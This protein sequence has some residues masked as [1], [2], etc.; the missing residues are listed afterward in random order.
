MRNSRD[1]PKFLGTGNRLNK[2]VLGTDPRYRR[3]FL[4]LGMAAFLTSIFSA[5]SSQLMNKYLEDVHGFSSS[6][7]A[8]FRT[9][10][11]GIPGLVGL[12]LGGRLAEKRGRRPVAAIG[13]AIATATQM[14]FFLD[15][16][17]HHLGD[18]GGLDPRGRCRR[19]RAR[20][21]RR[22]AVRHRS[23]VD[24]ERACSRSSVWSVRLSGLIAAGVLADPLGDLG[25]SIA[26][27]GI[28]SLVAA[29]FVVPRLPEIGR[30]RRSTT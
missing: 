17:Q 29:A 5:P 7:I 28:G 14:V 25:R 12:V 6:G 18:V 3:R 27:T 10:T 8:V 9:V 1:T 16:R 22:R 26:L 30:T 13:L 20:H 23:A 24:L 4:L 2:V 19:D 21:P 11:T 15:R